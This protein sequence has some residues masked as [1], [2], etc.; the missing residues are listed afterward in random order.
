MT[1]WRQPWWEAAAAAA[2][3]VWGRRRGAGTA[4]CCITTTRPRPSPTAAPR[5]RPAGGGAEVQRAASGRR[6]C[7]VP[8]PGADPGSLAALPPVPAGYARPVPYKQCGHSKGVV[9]WSATAVGWLVHSVPCWPCHDRGARSGVGP[10]LSEVQGPQTDRGQSFLFVALPRRAL[11]AVL[12]QLLHMQVGWARA[13]GRRW[14]ARGPLARKRVVGCGGSMPHMPAPSPPSLFSSLFSH[15]HHHP[16]GAGLLHL[17]PRGVAARARRLRQGAGARLPQP[18]A[19]VSGRGVEGSPLGLLPAA[20]RHAH[21]RAHPPACCPDT[22]RPP[23]PTAAHRPGLWHLGK[24]NE[25]PA[26]FYQHL[27]EGWGWQRWWLR[28][29]QVVKDVRQRRPAARGERGA[30]GPG[31]CGGGGRP[32]RGPHVASGPGPAGIH[33]WPPPLPARA[34]QKARNVVPS[35]GLLLNVATLEVPGFDHRPYQARPGWAGQRAASQ[36]GA[37]RAAGMRCR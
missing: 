20:L 21:A 33:A 25:P 15:T 36:A 29:N 5:V 3:A 8:A 22:A 1:G 17:R 2:W 27:S 4:A 9:L 18:A 31:R 28:T 10:R 34:P 37:C 16:P 6:C 12:Q 14:L 32:A 7:A 19:G 35:T 24:A 23:C 26:N 11:P 13:P 30:G